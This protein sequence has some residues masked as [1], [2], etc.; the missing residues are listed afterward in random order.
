MTLIRSLLHNRCK[1]T[2]LLVILTAT[3]GLSQESKVDRVVEFGEIVGRS[4]KP[5]LRHVH[6]GAMNDGTERVRVIMSEVSWNPVQLRQTFFYAASLDSDFRSIMRSGQIDEGAWF[7]STG[8]AVWSAK[9]KSWIPGHASLSLQRLEPIVEASYVSGVKVGYLPPQIKRLLGS[10]PAAGEAREK[11]GTSQELE[12]RWQSGLITRMLIT[13]DGKPHVLTLNEMVDTFLPMDGNALKP[14]PSV[15]G[16]TIS[17]D[18]FGS[19]LTA[20]ARSKKSVGVGFSLSDVLVVN[21]VFWG[22][23][24]FHAGLRRGDFLLTVNGLDTQSARDAAV[25]ALKESDVVTFSVL[26]PSGK[27]SVVTC[28]RSQVDNF[29]GSAGRIL[30]LKSREDGLGDA[31]KSPSGKALPGCCGGDK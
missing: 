21:D 25:A 20:E 15:R 13:T 26:K 30:L 27:R 24:A 17:G 3:A 28:T 18:A 29:V 1:G 22:S 11:I 8:V 19:V 14:N 31:L 2:V 16:E 6:A 7:H 4:S 23:P 5:V 10:S 9:Q 12:V